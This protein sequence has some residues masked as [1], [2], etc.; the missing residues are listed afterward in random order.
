[1]TL[2]YLAQINIARMRAPLTDPI[3]ADFVAQLDTINALA[4]RSPG[5]VWRLQS[6]GGNATD[7]RAFEDPLILVNM[8]VWTS[9]EALYDYTYR[10]SHSGVFRRRKEWFERLEPVYALWWVPAGHLPDV[11]EGKARFEQLRQ[12][13]P[14]PEAFH[15]KH[16]FPAPQTIPAGL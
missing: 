12:H 8:S 14:S 4:E 13:G 7:I 1:M 9:I 3:M 16:R 6:E 2:Y 15:F 10:S 5:F 11:T